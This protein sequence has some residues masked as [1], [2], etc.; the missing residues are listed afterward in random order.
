MSEQY[1]MVVYWSA[2]DGWQVTEMEPASDGYIWD[3][4]LEEWSYASTDEQMETYSRLTNEFHA[5]LNSESV[6]D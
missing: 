5:R 3:D 2:E 4:E 1:H 6:L